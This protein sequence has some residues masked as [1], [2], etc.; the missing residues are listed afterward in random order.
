MVAKKK[1]T[2]SKKKAK[3]SKSKNKQSTS[4]KF[5]YLYDSGIKVPHENITTE[6]YK[7][8][9]MLIDGVTIS[10]VALELKISPATVHNWL[11]SDRPASIRFQQAF[12]DE[13]KR[14][15]EAMRLQS[16]S[17]AFDMYNLIPD[18]IQVLKKKAGK[19]SPKEVSI[20]VTYLN[21][22]QY[23]LKDDTKA[24]E[25]KAREKILA[26]L[27]QLI[28]EKTLESQMQNE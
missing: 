2:N 27:E 21:S 20:I 15:M 14:R 22:S 12:K 19:F 25:E 24:K 13:T 9:C 4:S 16:D 1:V 7:A 28:E 5:S 8:M 3:T 26:G 10:K 18:W 6:Q 23:L 11:Y 17:I